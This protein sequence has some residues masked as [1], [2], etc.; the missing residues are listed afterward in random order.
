M[1]AEMYPGA[2]DLARSSRYF[3]ARAALEVYNQTGAVPSVSDDSSA[4]FR[5]GGEEAS[6]RVRHSRL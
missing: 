6:L 4:K 3:I 1:Y 5:R 2:F